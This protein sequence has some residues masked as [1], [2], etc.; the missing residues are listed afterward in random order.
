MKAGSARF[1]SAVSE[2]TWVVR[3]SLSNPQ[4]L[5]GRPTGSAEYTWSSQFRTNRLRAEFQDLPGYPAPGTPEEFI[6]E[7]YWGYTV[8]KDGGTVEYRVEHPRWKIWNADTFEVHAN[9]ATLYGDQF[10]AT[11]SDPPH[12]AFIA[13]GSP[14]EIFKRTIEREQ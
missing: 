14:I 11:L 6:T 3:G 1:A 7:H 12:S 9:V 4:M 5:K 2:R 8:Q 13:D 10:A